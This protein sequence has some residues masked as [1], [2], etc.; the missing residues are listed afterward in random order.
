MKK[1]QMFEEFYK[2]DQTPVR[3][4]YGRSGITSRF[5]QIAGENQFQLKTQKLIIF[6]VLVIILGI[7]IVWSHLEIVVILI[8]LIIFVGSF[9][10]IEYLTKPRN[11]AY[12][13]RQKIARRCLDV[14]E[15]E[16]SGINH[17]DLK[18]Y[19]ASTKGEISES[20]FDSNVR[21]FAAIKK[22]ISE[23]R[24]FLLKI[25]RP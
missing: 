23:E 25:A 12:S 1:K 2:L 15:V 20:E 6:L 24:L 14:L 13:F 4:N 11:I 9:Q 7:W 10:T 21:K 3:L 16:E 18:S 5:L 17:R 8:S 19:E 22:Q